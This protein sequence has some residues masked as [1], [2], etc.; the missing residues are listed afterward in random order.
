MDTVDS[1]RKLKSISFDAKR[2]GTERVTGDDIT[3]LR[4]VTGSLAWIARQARPDLAY[5]VSRLQSSI[6]NASVATL[7]DANAVVQLAHKGDQVKLRFPRGRL[8]WDEVGVITDASFSNGKDYKSQQ[9]RCHFLGD[10]TEIK[11][12]N[13]NGHRVMPLPFSSTTIRCVCV[14]KHSQS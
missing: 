13:C 9:G 8:K 14:S 11:D 7:A 3:R 1:T 2:S 12:N 4:S 6:K 5:R 10:L